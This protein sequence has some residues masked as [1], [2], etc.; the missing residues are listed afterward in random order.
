MKTKFV[1]AAAAATLAGAILI[2]HLM[3]KKST[4]EQPAKVPVKKTHHLT[5]VF[6]HAKNH[7]EDL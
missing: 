3:N 5:D 2:K 4:V 6:A 1:F 7:A